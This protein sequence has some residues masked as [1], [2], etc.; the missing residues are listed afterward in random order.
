[1]PGGAEQLEE[2]AAAPQKKDWI[3]DGFGVAVSQMDGGFPVGCPLNHPPT[4]PSE[5][6]QFPLKAIVEILLPL[7]NACVHMSNFMG[8]ARQSFIGVS[9]HFGACGWPFLVQDFR[10][11]RCS[12]AV[13]KCKV[14]VEVWV[15]LLS[16]P[17][18]MHLYAHTA[19]R[20]YEAISC[21]QVVTAF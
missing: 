21:R 3:R 12:E 17:L 5:K 20:S 1:M 14:P 9:G 6:L 2:N 18:A 13:K 7:R 15:P 10:I 11:G 19:T 8:V 16:S 4:I